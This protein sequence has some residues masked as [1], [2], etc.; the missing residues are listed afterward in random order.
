M[1]SIG[2]LYSGNLKIRDTKIVGR[3]P[4]TATKLKTAPSVAKARVQSIADKVRAV[5]DTVSG[6]CLV[7]AV[8]WVLI[9]AEGG[10]PV[11]GS[12]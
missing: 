10:R 5:W 2:M 4:L 12:R 6:S 8:I 3:R 7:S 11:A 9:G 1:L